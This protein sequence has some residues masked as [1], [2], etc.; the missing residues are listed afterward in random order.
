MMRQVQLDMLAGRL[1][2][3][4]RDAGLDRRTELVSGG[5]A[6]TAPAVSDWRHPYF[7][8]SFTVSGADGPIE[9]KRGEPSQ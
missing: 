9:L 4:T 3:A 1:T 7:W 2:P 5:S 6:V 8:A